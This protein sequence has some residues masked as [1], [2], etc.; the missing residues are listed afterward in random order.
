MLGVAEHTFVYREVSDLLFLGSLS[1]YDS[2]E[3]TF[4]SADPDPFQGIGTENPSACR[5]ID[6]SCQ[7]GF[8]QWWAE[9][10]PS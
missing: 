5:W 3:S 6:L 7:V 9:G 10:A 1:L 8:E 2:K 4:T